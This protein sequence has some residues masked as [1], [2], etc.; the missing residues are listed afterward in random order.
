VERI[1]DADPDV[2]LLVYG[3]F[4]DTRNEVPSRAGQGKDGG[5]R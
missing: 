1:F 2:N 5:E 4:N 3:D